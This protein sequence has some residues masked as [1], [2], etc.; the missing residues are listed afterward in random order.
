MGDEYKCPE[1]RLRELESRPKPLAREAS[2]DR[3]ERF[4]GLHASEASG[5]A[6]AIQPG[7]AGKATEGSAAVAT[8]RDERSQ[9]PDGLPRR[10]DAS[11]QPITSLDRPAASAGTVGGVVGPRVATE[12]V[13]QQFTELK[14]LFDWVGENGGGIICGISLGCFACQAFTV[15]QF[16]AIKETVHRELSNNTPQ[17]CASRAAGGA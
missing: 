14:P 4:D 9:L 11:V 2:G 16:A 17:R 1:C 10:G 6:S 12:L 7:G 13:P 5:T 8:L 15:K 3:V